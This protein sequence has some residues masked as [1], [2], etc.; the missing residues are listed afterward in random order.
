MSD[1]QADPTDS[2]VVRAREVIADEVAA[3][4]AM[5]ERLG[6][7][8]AAAVERILGCK[9]K[10]VLT[11]MGKHGHVA[12]KIAATLASTGTPASFLH[13]AEGLHGDLGMVGP[14]DVVIAVS[15]S[16]ST[17]EVLNC[18]P[19]FQRNRNTLIAM[20]GQPE[21][22]LARQADLVLDCSVSREVCPLNL[23]PT[24]STTAA[25]VLGDALAVVL[26]ERRGFGTEDFAV[27][28]PSGALGRKL[29]LRVEDVI[30]PDR[31]PIV[32]ESDPLLKAVGEITRH[33]VGAV[34]VTGPE[35][36]LTGVVTDGDMRRI[37]ERAAQDAS[38]S[39]GDLLNG[40][41]GQFMT[42]SPL[43]T[44]SDALAAQALSLMEDGPRKVSVLPV[45]DGDGRPV[46]MVHI[47][48]LI[49]AGI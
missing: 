29:L 21:S 23:A 24:S 49:S 40:A 20:T 33:K 48:D 17:E 30:Q 39:V 31:N 42:R 46:G 35:G 26:L 22:E 5:A 6:P 8:F 47:H 11:G 38:T 18:L 3:L 32:L 9:G 12:R 15:N 27:R 41:S 36:R 44:T 10:V 19:Y 45:V 37:L 43:T 16:G 28:H 25:L 7:E 1:S 14:D 13:P 34:S 2:S 4:Q